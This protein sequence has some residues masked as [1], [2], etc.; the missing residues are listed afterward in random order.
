MRARAGCAAFMVHDSAPGSRAPRAESRTHGADASG[1]VYPAAGI[2]SA[3]SAL[4]VDRHTATV[5]PGA[6]A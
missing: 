3:V 4:S 2:G 5:T 6:S 1:P